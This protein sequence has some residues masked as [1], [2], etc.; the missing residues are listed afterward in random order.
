VRVSIDGASLVDR[1]D[2][3]AVPV[4]PGEHRFVFSA[5]GEEDVTLRAVVVEG[6]RNRTVAVTFPPRNVTARPEPVAARPVPIGVYAAG[7]AALVAAGVGTY[8]AVSGMYGHPGREELLACRPS[9]PQGDVD[10]VT[11]KLVAADVSLA[12]ALVA[13]GIGVVLYLTRP[14][15]RAIPAT[16]A[17]LLF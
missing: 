7:A 10:A 8:F 12:V 1:L 11:H 3:H 15:S 16:A 6:E 17:A 2:G 4:D 14:T 5:R 13:A 9:C